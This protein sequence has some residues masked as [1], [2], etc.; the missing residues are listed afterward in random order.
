MRKK[1]SDLELGV[2]LIFGGAWLIIS[3]LRRFRRKRDVEDTSTAKIR[4]APQGSVEVQ[5]YA[6]PFESQEK[7]NLDDP[8]WEP[9]EG[10]LTTGN[11]RCLALGNPTRPE[12]NFYRIFTDNSK[13]WRTFTFNAEYSELVSKEYCQRMLKKYGRDSDVYRVRVLGEF[14]SINS[15]SFIPL[16]LCERSLNQLIEDNIFRKKLGVD[17]ARFGDDYTVF[18]VRMGGRIMKVIKKSHI[19]TMEIVGEIQRIMHDETIE[20]KMYL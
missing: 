15:N 6:W 1:H 19:D 4:S 10:A 9:V 7:N 13:F 12:G 17:I 5:G 11:A 18:L 20:K 16:Y 8:I 3:G 2:Y 14:P